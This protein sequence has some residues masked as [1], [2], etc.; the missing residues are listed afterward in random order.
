MIH[1]AWCCI[2]DVPYN[3]SGHPSNLKVT[4]AKNGRFESNLSKITRPVAA[5]KSLRFAL[6]FLAT[7]LFFNFLKSVCFSARKESAARKFRLSTSTPH[8]GR[9]VKQFPFEAHQSELSQIA[10]S[11][12]MCLPVA[13]PAMPSPVGDHSDIQECSVCL[14]SLDPSGVHPSP[15]TSHFS[16]ISQVSSHGN[17]SNSNHTCESQ[18]ELSRPSIERCN[19]NLRSA[20]KKDHQCIHPRTGYVKYHAKN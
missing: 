20:A 6:F 9:T 5:I 14:E 15:A 3:F 4:R 19:R 17:E 7:Y 18:P 1:K 2:E 12:V 8:G 13:L 10:S 11:P 16:D